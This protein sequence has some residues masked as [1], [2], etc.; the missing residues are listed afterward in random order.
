MEQLPE[1]VSL[2]M[3]AVDFALHLYEINGRKEGE[4]ILS[5]ANQVYE[6]LKTGKVPEKDSD[7]A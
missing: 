3:A 6:F 1:D 2:R 7:D 5:N 4:N